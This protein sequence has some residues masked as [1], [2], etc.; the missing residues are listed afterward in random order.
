M[1]SVAPTETSNQ[2]SND[3]LPE[4]VGGTLQQSSDTHNKRTHED[5]LASTE[6]I[7]NPDCGNR[8]S[9]A[10]QIVRSDDDTLTKTK[11]SPRARPVIGAFRTR[12]C[13]YLGESTGYFVARE[14]SSHSIHRWSR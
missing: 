7:A 14:S 2:A 9:K 1:D 3:E 8:S 5:R 11:I 10:T 4:L 6:H 13:T 12:W